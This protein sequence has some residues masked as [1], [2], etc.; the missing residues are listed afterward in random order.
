MSDIVQ[1]VEE[2]VA[3]LGELKYAQDETNVAGRPVR[4]AA[5][6]GLEVI[7]ALVEEY[8]LAVRRFEK[9]EQEL[10]RVAEKVT[11]YDSQAAKILGKL[12]KVVIDRD[13]LQERVDAFLV[14]WDRL[15]EMRKGKEKRD[16]EV[17]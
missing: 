16:D 2:I 3:I 11:F 17:S 9:A 4:Y 8:T 10:G 6:L 15:M 1:K 5:T 7:S 13:E 14:A 12:D